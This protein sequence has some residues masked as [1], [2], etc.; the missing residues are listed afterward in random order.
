MMRTTKM[1]HRHL[2]GIVL[3]GAVQGC[4]KLKSSG[5]VG[6]ASGRARSAIEVIEHSNLLRTGMASLPFAFSLRTPA[7]CTSDEGSSIPM[8]RRLV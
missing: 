8:S 4:W 3:C 2:C 1:N 7:G 6:A 5:W